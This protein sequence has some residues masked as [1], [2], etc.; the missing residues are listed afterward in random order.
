M[1]RWAADSRLGK[2]FRLI[3]SAHLLVRNGRLHELV[4]TASSCLARGEVHRLLRWCRETVAIEQRLSAKSYRRW[5]L[6]HEVSPDELTVETDAHEVTVLMV[7]DSSISMDALGLDY[8]LARDWKCLFV[9]ASHDGLAEPTSAR[10]DITV[11]FVTMDAHSS[12][13]AFDFGLAHVSTKFVLALTPGARLHPQTLGLLLATAKRTDADLIYSD[14]DRM[15]QGVRAD[16]YFKPDFSI[17][18]HRAEDYIGPVVLMR[19]TVVEPFL[20]SDATTHGCIYRLVERLYEAN[21][22]IVH[23]PRVLVHWAVARD[24]N[25]AGIRRSS[26]MERR[27]NSSSSPVSASAASDSVVSIVIPTRDRIDLLAECLRSVYESSPRLNFE[28][29][30]LNNRSAE[31]RSMQWLAQASCKYHN[32]RV[33]NAD[34]DFNW[35]RL[36]NHGIELARGDVFIFLNNDVEVI[37]EDWMTGLVKQATRPEVGAVG[38]LLLYPDGAIQH[39]GIVVGMSGF[40]DHLYVGYS[41][42]PEERHLFVSPYLG[43]NVLACTGACLAI[44]RRKLDKVGLFDESFPTSGDVEMCLRLIDKGYLNVYDPTVRLYHHESQTRGTGPV[45]SAEVECLR[46]V[47]QPYLDDGDPYYNENLSLS[48]RYPTFVD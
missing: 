22:K 33:V 8:Q 48:L 13:S 45:D 44:E 47:L 2:S 32:L 31:E 43:R 4:K 24:R 11:D 19:R 23:V 29:I 34:Y 6:D 40:A 26:L 27:S 9:D 37:S 14:E 1:A 39:G 16:P 18:L 38:G 15:I 21:A 10:I 20:S 35:S 3:A 41:G 28:L 36:C 17:D 30:V 46:P 7:V 25:V 12:H 42:G 5:R